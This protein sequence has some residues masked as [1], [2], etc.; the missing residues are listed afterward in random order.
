MYVQGN[1]SVNRSWYF[2]MFCS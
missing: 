1:L 2:Y